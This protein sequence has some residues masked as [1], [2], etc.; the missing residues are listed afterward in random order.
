MQEAAKNLLLVLVTLFPIV[1]ILEAA[2]SGADQG[3]LTR[4]AKSIVLAHRPQQ[5]F[6]AGCGVFCRD[7]HPRL[8]WYFAASGAGRRRSDRYCDRMDAAE[9]RR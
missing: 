4:S 5:F 7:L 3:I 9:A 6:L 2:L 8:F 1:N